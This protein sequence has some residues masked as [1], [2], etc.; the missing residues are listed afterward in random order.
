MTLPLSRPYTARGGAPT[1]DRV[2]PAIFT[3]S[4]F[5]K[6]MECTF[7]QDSCCQ[8]GADIEMPRVRALEAIADELE[9]Y[10]GTPRS[11]WFRTDPEDI[12]ILDEAEYPGGQYT[13]T[14]VVPKPEGRSEHFT[15]ACTFLDPVGRGCRIH[16]FAL[17]RNIDVHDIKPLICLIFP[18]CF[19][20][21][22]LH[23]ALELETEELICM[24]TGPNLYRSSR[25]EVAYYFGREMVKELD[26]ME[27][28]VRAA[29]P[30]PVSATIPLTVRSE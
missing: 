26:A 23:P 10:L 2:D 18:L 15:E 25:D 14:S 8:Y 12:G 19:D 21:G 3:L 22:K 28:T 9:P 11:E 6:C 30:V 29:T 27:A 4:Y 13:R 7:C 16:R 5:A 20:K 17:E 1:I 24:G